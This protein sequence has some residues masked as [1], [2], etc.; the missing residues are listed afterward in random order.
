MT[1]P[2]TTPANANFKLHY[3]KIKH[4]DV[5]IRSKQ[6]GEPPASSS[7]LGGST[8]AVS[9]PPPHSLLREVQTFNPIYN[10]FFDLNSQSW[11]KIV[12]NNPKH[13]VI[14]DPMLKS[15]DDRS[16]TVVNM[17]T[18]E[19]EVH[20]TV[21]RKYAPLLDPV[22][23]MI[24]KYKLKK[25][26]QQA[27]C[28][29]LPTYRG[30]GENNNNTDTSHHSAEVLTK[31]NFF[32]NAA[33]VDNFFNFL[34]GTVCFHHHKFIHGVEYFGSFIGIQDRF[35]INVVDEV[36]YLQESPYFMKNLG[37]LFSLNDDQLFR[38]MSSRDS[39]E[40]GRG[41]QHRHHQRALTILDETINIAASLELEETPAVG[42]DVGEIII[43]EDTMA[44]EEEAED[45]TN[46]DDSGSD[47]DDSYSDND[48]SDSENDNTTSSGS[49]VGDEDGDDGSD[50][51][52]V[53]DEDDEEQEEEEDGDDGGDSGEESKV[54][55]EIFDFPVQMI[56]QERCDATLDSLFESG[57]MDVEMSA[58]M[59]FQVIMILAA[60][61]KMFDFTHNDL[62]TN[63]IMFVKT[64]E[65][66]LYYLYEERW[67]RVPTYGRVF[68]II[69]FGRAIYKYQNKLFCSD[70]FD[71]F[72]DA[73]TQYNS[74]PFYNPRNA[75][76]DPNPAFDLTRLASSIYDFV[77]D[78]RQTLDPVALDKDFDLFQ[79]LIYSWCL[80]DN[81][82]NI[83]YKKNGEERYPCFRLYKMIAKTVH[84][85]TPQRQLNND[86][87]R[88][89]LHTLSPSSPPPPPLAIV[90]IDALPVYFSC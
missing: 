86:L 44:V 36:D 65:P 55:A 57:D 70:S 20:H 27:Y 82:K 49:E 60:Y 75:R 17:S 11:D 73:H 32:Q 51:S 58:S 64:D 67:Y 63:N 29:P 19:Q 90:N 54:M 3:F 34:I 13:L 2:T 74:E 31:I 40:S 39:R 5:V 43:G 78:H 41:R 4:V 76:I 12:I 71:T 56:C 38:M 69:D 85:H 50:G 88:P 47:N 18:Y 83:L 48:D 15:N 66:F 81:G 10:E 1:P 33:Y 61:Q 22:R 45:T 16:S 37:K 46:N 68:K 72:G 87:F 80:D 62:H 24:G 53:G 14:S 8:T 28:L 59:I 9:P 6:S 23:Y 84:N 79:K 77:I 26:Q 30:T 89:F 7:I 35:Q 25:Q 52:E 42:V 21:F